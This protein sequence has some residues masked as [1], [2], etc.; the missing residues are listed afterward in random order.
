M[1]QVLGMARILKAKHA[2]NA[3]LDVGLYT[4]SPLITVSKLGPLRWA[5]LQDERHT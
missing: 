4:L 5:I 1:E 3:V 2:A